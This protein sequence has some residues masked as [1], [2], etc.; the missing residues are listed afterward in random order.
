[1]CTKNKKT[2]LIMR[3]SR[4][5]AVFLVISAVVCGALAIIITIMEIM[6]ILIYHKTMAMR[7]TMEVEHTKVLPRN[8]GRVRRKDVI[9]F[10]VPGAYSGYM[11]LNVSAKL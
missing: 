7:L 6:I 4:S 2:C 9:Y 8:N 1:M 10:F 11:I 5:A 3:P